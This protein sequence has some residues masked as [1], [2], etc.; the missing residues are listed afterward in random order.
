MKPLVLLGVDSGMATCGVCLLVCHG[1]RVVAEGVIVVRTKQNKRYKAMVDEDIRLRAIGQALDD[2][3]AGRDIDALAYE[4][5]RPFQKKGEQCPACKRAPHTGARGRLVSKGEGAVIGYGLAIGVRTI[6]VDPAEPRR[7]LNA[8]SKA[9]VSQV[10]EAKIEGL[11]ALLDQAGRSG[12]HGSDAAA[13][14]Y[15]GMVKIFEA[16][17]TR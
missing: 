17:R 8:H 3:R 6:P 13:C 16:Q 12:F 4:Y 11:T 10:L 14:A 15:V 5:Y 2:M 9:A 7:I 1:D